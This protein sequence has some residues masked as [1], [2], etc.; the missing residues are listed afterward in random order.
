M[1]R[2]L[3]TVVLTT[4]IFAVSASLP[5]H[6]HTVKAPTQLKPEAMA[7]LKAQAGAELIKTSALQPLAGNLTT[8]L[9]LNPAASQPGPD[10]EAGWRYNAALLSTLGLIATIALRRHSAGKR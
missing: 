7:V 9:S 1:C 5:L 4:G 8:S 6:A 2:V 3:L 10:D